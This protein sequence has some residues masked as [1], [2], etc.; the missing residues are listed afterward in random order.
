MV[1]R[2]SRR[3]KCFPTR[4]ALPVTRLPIACADL[5]AQIERALRRTA[6][7]RNSSDLR[8]EAKPLLPIVHDMAATDSVGVL[9]G[10][11]S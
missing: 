10:A 7:A 6:L 8:A 9:R 2:R 5:E 1:S 11:K 4:P 3:S